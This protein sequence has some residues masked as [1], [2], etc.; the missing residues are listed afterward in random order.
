[1]RTGAHLPGNRSSH[2]VPS[3]PRNAPG[4]CSSGS[5]HYGLVDRSAGRISSLTVGARCS[6]ARQSG[7]PKRASA[8]PSVVFEVLG[9]GPS[10]YGQSGHLIMERFVPFASS[11]GR[12]FHRL[13][14]RVWSTAEAARCVVPPAGNRW[15]AARLWLLRNVV[16]GRRPAMELHR[17]S[18]TVTRLGLDSCPLDEARDDSDQLGRVHGLG[19]VC[20]EP[21]EQ[22]SPAV[23]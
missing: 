8:F 17:P 4:A 14:H 7:T 19:D 22:R 10:S 2:R 5:A 1:M 6:V 18:S 21:G 3:H 16:V 15:I 20:L 23:L 13:F 12:S 11:A 9:S